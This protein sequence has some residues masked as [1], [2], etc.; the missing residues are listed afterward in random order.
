MALL[1]LHLVVSPESF[2]S[3]SRGAAARRIPGIGAEPL[4][5]RVMMREHLRALDLESGQFGA[6]SPARL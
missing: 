4:S 1:S 6:A 2:L 5:S 3:F